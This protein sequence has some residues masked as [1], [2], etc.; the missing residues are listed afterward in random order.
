MYRE[1]RLLLPVAGATRRS[2]FHLATTG[3]VQR[4]VKC[5]LDTTNIG[6]ETQPNQ[7]IRVVDYNGDE[8]LNQA[9]FKI[10]RDC[11]GVVS[12]FLKR[13]TLTIPVEPGRVQ[14]LLPT[15]VVPIL[16]SGAPPEKPAATGATKTVEQMTVAER[17]AAGL[18]PV[19]K[20]GKVSWEA[21]E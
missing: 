19:S 21:P 10:N 11:P 7:T 6:F 9:D 12:F 18:R 20:D 5:S 14:T 3:S 4:E 15:A 2:V 1:F 8:V 13:D 17:L 16:P